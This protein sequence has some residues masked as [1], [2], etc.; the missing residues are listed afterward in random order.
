MLIYFKQRGDNME[1]ILVDNV[2][3]FTGLILKRRKRERQKEG[4]VGVSC[5]YT[6]FWLEGYKYITMVVIR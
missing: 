4:T 3:P 1:R 5:S 2:D 6:H